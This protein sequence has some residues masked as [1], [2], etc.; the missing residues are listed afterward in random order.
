MTAENSA[1]D[2]ILYIG[3]EKIVIEPM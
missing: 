2:T 1:K 3:D